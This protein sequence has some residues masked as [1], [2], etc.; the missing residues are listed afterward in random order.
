MTSLAE[1]T[2]KQTCLKSNLSYVESI[3]ISQ[4]EINRIGDIY[5]GKFCSQKHFCDNHFKRF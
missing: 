1:S 2:S 3:E 5:L 4:N